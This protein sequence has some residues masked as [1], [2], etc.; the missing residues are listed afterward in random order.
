MFYLFV[1]YISFHFKIQ[2]GILPNL[3]RLGIVVDKQ[4]KDAPSV[5]GMHRYL[6]PGDPLFKTFQFFF[7]GKDS[8]DSVF[9]TPCSCV[10]PVSSFL[11]RS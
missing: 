2:A 5:L 10:C 4:E 6:P 8:V 7:P 3:R 11:H 1:K 9:K